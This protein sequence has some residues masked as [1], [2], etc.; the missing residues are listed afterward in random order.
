MEGDYRSM[1]KSRVPEQLYTIDDI[2]TL[3]PRCTEYMVRNYRWKTKIGHV[4]DN[5]V[6][7]TA[8]EVT[9]FV[10]DVEFEN[11]SR[12]KILYEYIKYHPGVKEDDLYRFLPYSKQII[13]TLLVDIS[14]PEYLSEFPDLY[15]EDD[16][17]LYIIGHERIHDTKKC[18]KNEGIFFSVKRRVRRYEKKD[19]SKKR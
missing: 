16:G 12:R 17:G 7:Y 5:V 14:S 13:S 2:I 3:F 19:V 10:E 9:R 1:N 11:I 6:Y 18:T 4:I 8:D 15:E